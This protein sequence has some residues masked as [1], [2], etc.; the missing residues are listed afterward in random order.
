MNKFHR[1]TL[2]KLS[3][4]FAT[5]AMDEFDGH[6]SIEGMKLRAELGISLQEERELREYFKDLFRNC[7]KGIKG[8]GKGRRVE[9]IV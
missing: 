5:Y 2:A 6:E 3:W 7:N 9:V 4:H 8:R 1:E